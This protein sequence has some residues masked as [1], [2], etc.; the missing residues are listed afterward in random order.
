M[1]LSRVWLEAIRG[2]TV[3]E[4]QFRHSSL[5]TLIFNMVLRSK[6]VGHGD[7]DPETDTRKCE[8]SSSEPHQQEFKNPS[9]G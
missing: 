6:G 7:N 4:H 3:S 1:A 2:L 9:T 8:F 5:G